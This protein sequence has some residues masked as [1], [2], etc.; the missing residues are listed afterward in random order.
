MRNRLL[1]NLALLVG[2]L[3]LGAVVWLKPGKPPAP[4]PVPLTALKADAVTR[5]AVDGRGDPFTLERQ[6]GTWFLVAGPVRLRARQYRVDAL[7]G[8]VSA[9]RLATVTEGTG[10][11]F[12]L[13]P[14]AARVRF[15]D[16]EIALGD[17]NPVDFRRYTHVGDATYLTDDAYFHHLASPWTDWADL[18][19]L[20]PGASLERV[21]TPSY[22][23]TLNAQGAYDLS[24]AQAGISADTLVLRA[25]DWAAVQ[26]VATRAAPAQIPAQTTALELTYREP[27]AAD[28]V[29]LRYALERQAGAV[30]AHRR[31]LPVSFEIALAEAER[32]L[33]PLV[34]EPPIEDAPATDSP[35]AEPSSE[36]TATPD[37][38]AMADPAAPAAPPPAGD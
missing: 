32:L 27:G 5:I 34:P 8:L 22:T 25:Q 13:D 1:I 30:L 37:L 18:R 10:A 24:P 16:T 26:A 9:P 23:L 19:L 20:P 21:V 33:R 12:G 29:T 4:L 7:L 38:P 11:D 17:S 31:D 28:P 14:P 2:A 3:V 15:D 35:P 36:G 6:D